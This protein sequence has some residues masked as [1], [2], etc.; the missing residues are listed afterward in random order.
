MREILAFRKILA[1]CDTP[2][3]IR[4]AL[5]EAIAPHGFNASA[6][7]A[8]LP[9]QRGPQPF[10]FFVDW[11]EAWLKLYTERNYVAEDFG[12]SE[13][14]RRVAPFTWRQACAE[15][16][17]SRGEAEIWRTANEWG[18]VDGFSVPIHGPGG[19]LAIVTMACTRVG[20]GEEALL[21]LHLAA[22]AVHDRCRALTGVMALVDPERALTA[23]ELECLRWVAAGKTDWEV[24]GILGISP[25]TV[26]THVD[27]ARRKFGAQTRPQAIA[28]LILSGL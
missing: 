27:Q 15:R 20:I 4:D 16:T 6:C 22:L 17:L 13:A 7:G 5:R 14:R 3:D 28:R 2:S 25:E 10:F 23:R 9:T 18:W 12:V 11:P 1:A 8:F 26:R 24:A 21:F 19:Y